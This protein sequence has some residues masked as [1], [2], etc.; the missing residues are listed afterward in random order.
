VLIGAFA[1]G[2]STLVVW[3]VRFLRL[4][5]LRDPR[6]VRAITVPTPQGPRTLTIGPQNPYW[7]PIAAA[8]RALVVCVVRAEDAKFFQHD[9]FDWDQMEDSL[10]TDL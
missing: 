8:S 2:I 10:E 1:L 6:A 9:G 3:E 7:T 5:E 4:G